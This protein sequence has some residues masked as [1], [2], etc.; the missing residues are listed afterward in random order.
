MQRPP[1]PLTRDLVMIGGGHAHALVLRRWGMAPVP[2]VRLTVINPGPTAPY[3]GMLPGHVAGHYGRADL[4]IDL[5]KLARFAGAHLILGAATGIDRDR[6]LVH[7]AGRGPVFY[8]I[9]S[10]D[11]GI[12]SAMPSLP[13]FAEF[14]VPAKPLGVF[15]HRWAAFVD[16]VAGSTRPARVAVIGAGV[17]GVEL[18]LAMAH[19][20][21][22]AG[23]TGATVTLIETGQALSALKPRGRRMLKDRL[24]RTGIGLL[25]QATLTHLTGSA[26]HLADGRVLAFDFC[27]GAAGTRPHDW[28]ADTGLQLTDGFIDVGPDLRSLS[29][30]RLYS[31]GD[32]AHLTHAPRPKAGVFAVREAPVL[33]DNLK[34][35]LTGRGRR[36]PYRPQGDYLKLISLGGKDALVEK[37]SVTLASPLLW[38]LKNRIDQAFMDKFRALPAMTPPPLPA[39]RAEGLR[40]LVEDRPPLCGGCGAKLGPAP[41]SEVLA[42][43]PAPQ[44]PDLRS[45]PGDDA[46]VL[47]LGSGRVQVLT[48]DHLRPLLGDTW[49]MAQITALHA[50][51]DVWAM[52]AAP[53]IALAN[54]TLPA[55]RDEMQAATLADITAAASAVFRDAGADLAGGHTTQ[56]PELSI[57]FT[58]TG[59]CDGP[60]LCLDGARAGDMVILTRPIGTGTLLAAEMRGQAD[61]ADMAALY[62]LL[63][64]P[65][66]DAAALLTPEAHAMTDV[67]GFGLAGHALAMARASNL[68]LELDPD[69]VAVHAGA[70]ALAEAGLRSSLFAANKSHAAS[71]MDGFD[72]NART[73]LLFDPQTCGGFLAAVPEARAVALVTALR[74][75]GHGAAII[76]QMRAGA[77]GISRAVL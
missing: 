33:Y 76:G 38:R 11:V 42:G 9:A 28:I 16:Q 65:Q 53:Q 22:T 56:G 52:G 1:L 37:Q 77:P 49:R 4:D 19:R 20:L 66:A 34:A 35:D 15:A 74:D 32:C 54:L 59:L 70:L 24:A 68:H 48:T 50:L 64:T 73:D 57:G 43:L 12:T 5:V 29:D 55:M 13:G 17:A 40:E 7:V 21:R 47:D 14:G 71:A 30:P 6:R 31:V 51:G 60:P 23:A 3:S 2:G 72:G 27:T 39:I 26:L 45:G 18:A 46:A 63:C 75:L 25:E 69:R 44:R 36:R 10:I 62:D 58:V 8:D 41:L 67:T 61:G